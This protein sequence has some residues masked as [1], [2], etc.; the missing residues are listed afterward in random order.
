MPSSV[1][2]SSKLSDALLRLAPANILL[3][4]RNLICRYAAPMHDQ[5]EGR[6][7][8]ALIGLR[9]DQF[10]QPARDGLRPI[11]ESACREL[12][13]WHSEAYRFVETGSGHSRDCC[14]SIQVD[15]VETPDFQGV[16]VSWS[17]VE[18]T[19]REREG[20]RHEVE[21]LSAEANERNAALVEVISDIRNAITPLA[22]YLQ[23]LTRRPETFKNR[24]WR[25]V[26]TNLVLPR[27]A[28]VL[29]AT[30]RLRQTP[31]YTI[32]AEERSQATDT[33]DAP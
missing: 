5:F 10:L 29:D 28:D 4:D 2:L 1:R 19:E 3:F 25:E 30:E 21:R 20:L 16:L 27:V 7:R 18:A 17:D 9:A 6:P 15:P 23:V 32:E 11:L 24:S 12:R 14:W 26:I 31:I 33:T 13:A 22:G 8:E